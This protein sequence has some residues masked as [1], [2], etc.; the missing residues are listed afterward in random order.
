MI[1]QDIVYQNSDDADGCAKC[2]EI[3]ADV[4]TV[5]DHSKTSYIFIEQTGQSIPS[6]NQNLRMYN[7]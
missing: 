7:S 2:C 6:E 3:E 5:D 4:G 1:E